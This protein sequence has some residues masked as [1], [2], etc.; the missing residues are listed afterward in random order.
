MSTTSTNIIVDELEPTNFGEFIDALII[1]NLRM[2]HA[3]EFFYELD[4]LKKLDKDQMYE[5]LRYGSWLNLQRNF[6]M[7][8]LD[9]VVAAQL[10][11]RHPSVM[12]QTNDSVEQELLWEKV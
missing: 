5:K 10:A 1:T 2:W 9:A 4:L 8:G 3:Q 11:E 12:N 6:Q 7:D